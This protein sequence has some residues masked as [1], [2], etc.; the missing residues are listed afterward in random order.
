MRYRVTNAS[1]HEVIETDSLKFAFRAADHWIRE[2]ERRNDL[3]WYISDVT[4]WDF[5]K[6][7]FIYFRNK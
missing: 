6:N 4:V 7:E 5:K 2:T 1:T 3:P